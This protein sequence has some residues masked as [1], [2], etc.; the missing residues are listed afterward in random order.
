MPSHPT[1]RQTQSRPFLALPK[2]INVCL[3]WSSSSRVDPF[4]DMNVSLGWWLVLC[5]VL[6]HIIGS[7]NEQV[8][9]APGLFRYSSLI[10]ILF[11]LGVHG[12]NVAARIRWRQLG[13]YGVSGSFNWEFLF[14]G[15]VS[16]SRF[17]ASVM[18]RF[19]R[20]KRVASS[21][22]QVWNRTASAVPQI[23]I[24]RGSTYVRFSSLAVL[25]DNA[26]QK[27]E[28]VR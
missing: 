23:A 5:R 14:A 3:Q 6:S 15:S 18:L 16:V 19:W 2:C 13:A 8:H 4:H 10:A 12:S 21:V 28:G 11:G 17:K 25:F 7:L 26:G 24:Q 22:Q 9:D 27:I 1:S 20:L